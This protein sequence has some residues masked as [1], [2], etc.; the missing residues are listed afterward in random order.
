M[1]C[2]QSVTTIVL[3]GRHGQKFASFIVLYGRHGQKIAS[4]IVLDDRHGQ[5]SKYFGRIS[6]LFASFQVR[7][8]CSLF[9]CPETEYGKDAESLFGGILLP[10]HELDFFNGNNAPSA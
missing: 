8:A 4:F 1:E 6:S 7:I 10:F 9:C 2:N 3:Y 5:L